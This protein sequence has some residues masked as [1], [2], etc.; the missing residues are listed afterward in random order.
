MCPNTPHAGGPDPQDLDRDL[1]WTRVCAELT[2][3]VRSWVG[4]S[5]TQG[6]HRDTGARPTKTPTRPPASGA[7]WPGPQSPFLQPPRMFW[8]A[9]CGDCMC[10]SVPKS[11]DRATQAP[12][13][14]RTRPPA[15]PSA[16]SRTAT[17]PQRQGSAA[18][19][20]LGGSP[21]G[22]GGPSGAVQSADGHPGPAAE[23]RARP[24]LLLSL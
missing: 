21:T 9:L 5:D 16:L 24:P 10:P 22:P 8:A 12:R 1:P 17:T 3:T 14:R 18:P 6:R 19:G 13:P 11:G 15:R 23:K 2:D 4:G 20:P 7:L